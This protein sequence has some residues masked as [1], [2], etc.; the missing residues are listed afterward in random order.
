MYV[1]Q[2]DGS[3]YQAEYQLWDLALDVPIGPLEFS[4]MRYIARWKDKNGVRD[5]KKGLSYV[6]KLILANEDYRVHSG[7]VSQAE[8]QTQ[9]PLPYGLV[10]KAFTYYLRANTSIGLE[11]SSLLSE[12]LFWSSISDLKLI[13]AILKDMI[14]KSEIVNT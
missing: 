2:V 7:F 11:E 5:L 1:N 12:I 14:N 13:E 3:H 6:Q 8:R 9:V 4:A 10:N